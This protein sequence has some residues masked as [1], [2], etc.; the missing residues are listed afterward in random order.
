MNERQPD[1]WSGVGK[2]AAGSAVVMV[3]SLGLCGLSQG[4]GGLGGGL[5]IAGLL[6]F[7]AGGLGLLISAVIAIVIALSGGGTKPMPVAP[8]SQEADPPPAAKDDN[9]E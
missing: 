2:F 7:L 6:G 8:R 9:Q 4:N 5:A 1:K 3:V